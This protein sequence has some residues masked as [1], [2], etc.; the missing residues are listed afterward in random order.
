M[1]QWDWNQNKE[2][3]QRNV[4]IHTAVQEEFRSRKQCIMTASACSEQWG[5]MGRDDAQMVGKMLEHLA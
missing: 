5:F 3:A 2:E 1:P 4:G